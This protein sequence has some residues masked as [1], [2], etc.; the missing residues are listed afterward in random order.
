MGSLESDTTEHKV[1][2]PGLTSAFLVVGD[3]YEDRHFVIIKIIVLAKFGG[4]RGVRIEGA[5]NGYDPK[6]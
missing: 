3:L 4:K 1:I 5:N 2:R 6:R